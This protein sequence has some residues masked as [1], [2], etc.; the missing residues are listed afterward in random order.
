MFISI[1][2]HYFVNK[3]IQR[4]IWKESIVGQLE[5]AKAGRLNELEVET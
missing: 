2:R 4:N 5:S 3:V 1:I